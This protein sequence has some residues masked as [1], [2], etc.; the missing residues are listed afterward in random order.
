M[1]VTAQATQE[2]QFLTAKA[3]SQRYGFSVRHWLRMVDG[4]KAPLP[5]RFGRLTRWPIRTLEK[6]EADGCPSCRSNRRAGR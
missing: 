3:C 6:W 1:T 5:V 4:G 2:A